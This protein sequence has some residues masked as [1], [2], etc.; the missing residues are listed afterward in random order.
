MNKKSIATI[1]YAALAFIAVV[2]MVP[3]FSYNDPDTFWHIELGGYMVEHGMVL[4]HAIHTF[5]GDQL[6]YIPHE[7]GFQN[8]DCAIV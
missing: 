8:P 6:P 3:R 4:H 1:I 5:Y 2:C 7:F